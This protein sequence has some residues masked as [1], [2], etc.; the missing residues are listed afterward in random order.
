MPKK[1]KVVRRA[2]S[3]EDLRTLKT[4]AKRKARR[5]KNRQSLEANRQCD[6]RDGREATRV[7]EL[8]VNRSSRMKVENRVPLTNS[9][10]GITRQQCDAK[11]TPRDRLRR[12]DS[13]PQAGCARPLIRPVR[14]LSS[15]GARERQNC[16]NWKSRFIYPLIKRNN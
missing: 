2:W 3:K 15:T 5:S 14:P 7:V 4:M 11:E 9:K 8:A 6:A 10:V 1:K 12:R 16:T 13:R